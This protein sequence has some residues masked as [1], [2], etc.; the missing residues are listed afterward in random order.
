[1]FP[2][3]FDKYIK[4]DFCLIESKFF[5]CFAWFLEIIIKSGKNIPVLLFR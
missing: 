5:A 2:T 1:L 4:E 3:G